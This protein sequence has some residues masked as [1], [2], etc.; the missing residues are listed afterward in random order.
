MISKKKIWAVQL[1]EFPTSERMSLEDVYKWCD[2]PHDKTL[3]RWKQIALALQ[4]PHAVFYRIPNTKYM[5]FRFG[6]K[7]H[8]YMSLYSS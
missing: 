4:W 3:C 6:L 7:G 1:Q 5:G 2:E 8:Q